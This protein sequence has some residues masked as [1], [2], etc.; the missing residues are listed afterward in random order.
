MNDSTI[1]CVKEAHIVLLSL[2]N[3]MSPLAEVSL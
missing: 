3:Y 1:M 2:H